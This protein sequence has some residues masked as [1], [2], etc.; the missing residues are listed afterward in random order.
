MNG[1]ADKPLI[2]AVIP[3]GRLSGKL[4]NLQV[5]LSQAIRLPIEIV[6]VLDLDDNQIKQ[7][8]EELILTL[9]SPKIRLFQGVYGSPGKTR[10]TG[11]EH[12]DTKWICFWDA[13]DIAN[14]ENFIWMVHQGDIQKADVVIGNY[15]DMDF[16]SGEILKS[17]HLGGTLNSDLVSILANPGLWRFAFRFDAIK[18]CVFKDWKLAEDQDFL[19][20]SKFWEK[21]VIVFN[22]NVYRYNKNVGGQL[23]AT[24]RKSSEI[25]KSIDS[26]FIRV[27]QSKH[28]NQRKKVLSILAFDL[29]Q[30]AKWN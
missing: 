17:H 19:I 11:M 18:G 7:E 10:N 22:K 25:K 9:N 16:Q 5:T 26:V 12:V 15:V 30:N 4:K 3:V 2:T 14:V 8:A 6:V 27:S 23:T 20:Q 1:P 29:Y 13:D 28:E 24:F 21:D